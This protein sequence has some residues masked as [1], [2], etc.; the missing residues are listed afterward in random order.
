MHAISIHLYYLVLIIVHEHGVFFKPFALIC[1]IFKLK[2]MILFK[3][4]TGDTVYRELE[5]SE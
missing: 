2:K 1:K 5:G 4:A 3:S